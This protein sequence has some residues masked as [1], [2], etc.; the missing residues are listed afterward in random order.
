MLSKRPHAQNPII[1][2]LTLTNIFLLLA[3][4]MRFGAT[5]VTG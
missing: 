4:G 1:Q 3:T 2:L 5:K